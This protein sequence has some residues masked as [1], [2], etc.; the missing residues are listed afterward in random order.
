M[1]LIC[2]QLS[3]T[4]SCTQNFRQYTEMGLS[5][6]ESWPTPTPLCA[7]S[8]VQEPAYLSVLIPTGKFS[9]K[10][11]HH[12]C[13]VGLTSQLNNGEM[14]E[15]TRILASIQTFPRIAFPSTGATLREVPHRSGHGH[16][17]TRVVEAFQRA[18]QEFEEF[19][20]LLRSSG[21]GHS[22]TLG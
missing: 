22:R 1:F 5:S 16:F 3:L 15:H 13:F 21:A 14:N 20:H 19:P 7:D 17:Q 12:V 11:Q 9:C 6:L 2:L 4:T 18:A 8:S 10:R